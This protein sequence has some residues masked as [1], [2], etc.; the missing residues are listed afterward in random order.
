MTEVNNITEDE[1]FLNCK[2]PADI[3]AIAG[4]LGEFSASES[5]SIEKWLEKIDEIGI[6]HDLTSGEMIS[7]VIH[8]LRGEPLKW[9]LSTVENNMQIEWDEFR[10]A[11]QYRYAKKVAIPGMLDKVSNFFGF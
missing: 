3:V 8:A 11:L 9:A 6:V 2:L 4:I 5:Q 1:Q 10:A 7:A